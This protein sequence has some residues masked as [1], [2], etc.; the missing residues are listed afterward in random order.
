VARKVVVNIPFIDFNLS[1]L[2]LTGR[3]SPWEKRESSYGG[4]DL[5][6][7]EQV[8]GAGIDVAQDFE[9][10]LNAGL[11]EGSL[12][13]HEE[14]FCLGFGI[15]G[16]D[17]ALGMRVPDGGLEVAQLAIEDLL[18]LVAERCILSANLAS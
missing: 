5:G 13:K 6:G 11:G 14:R 7:S 4:L 16:N 9:V 3:L 1:D 18:N 2:Y 12:D 15:R 17:Q 8:E 10:V